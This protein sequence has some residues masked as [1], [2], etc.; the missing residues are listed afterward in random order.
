M[1]REQ[2]DAHIDEIM[3]RPTE[4]ERTKS[5]CV[6][7]AIA[8]HWRTQAE[9]QRD[10]LLA[11]CEA[12]AAVGEHGKTCEMCIAMAG[13]ALCNEALDL[14]SAA[15]KLTSAAIAKAKP[16]TDRASPGPL[17]QLP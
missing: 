2:L 14:Y 16:M 10:A 12:H 1:N 6:A 17:P 7:L 3:S 5:L 9:A 15:R 4:D 8:E 11:A 13:D